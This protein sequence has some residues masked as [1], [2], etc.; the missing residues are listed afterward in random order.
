VQVTAEVTGA[1]TQTT[2]DAGDTLTVT[3]TDTQTFGFVT[4]HGTLS[5][6]QTGQ[7]G[8]DDILT[9]S[10]S[11]TVNADVARFVNTGRNR[12]RDA[13]LAGTT[14]TAFEIGFSPSTDRPIRSDDSVSGPLR[15]AEVVNFDLTT[16]ITIDAGDTLTVAAGEVRPSSRAV[17]S[18]TL[19]VNGELQ[20]LDKPAT[21][22]DADLQ[23]AVETRT[24]G[25]I[26]SATD[27]LI[28]LARLE[29]TL[30]FVNDAQIAISFGPD[31]EPTTTFTR[32]GLEFLSKVLAD[33]PTSFPTSYAYG[34]DDTLPALTDTAL[35]NEVID[36]NFDETVVQDADSDAEWQSIVNL[37]NTDPQTVQNGKL[38]NRQS[39]FLIEGETSFIT[40][41]RGSPAYSDGSATFYGGDF[42]A[43][44][45]EA[46]YD[47]TTDYRIEN[48]EFYVRVERFSSPNTAEDDAITPGV[49]FEVDGTLIEEF[50]RGASF[51]PNVL[52]LRWFKKDRDQPADFELPAG[53]HTISFRITETTGGQ[54]LGEH[55]IDMV[56]I[57]DGDVGHTFDNQVHEDNGYLDAPQPFPPQTVTTTQASTS[58]DSGFDRARLRTTWNDTSGQQ[59]IG[60]SADGS[61]FID[62]SNTQVVTENIGATN[63]A[64]AR[65]GIGNYS[66]NGPRNQSPRLG[67]ESQK[68][69]LMTLAAIGDNLRAEDIG[70]LRL[71]ALIG[72]NDAVGETFAEAG[73]K[74]ADGTLLTR[75]LVP[76]FEKQQGQNVFSSEILSW[77]NEDSA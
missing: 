54:D 64:F 19:T 3:D 60:I 63:E 57:V 28:A 27:E 10:A 41:S 30:P 24:V 23:D 77:Q 69:D 21:S 76:A 20:V 72:G 11:S 16:D 42:A 2:V 22:F 71:Q 32:Q 18:G 14:L 75:S 35:G 36:T 12:L 48:P 39:A 65:F 61:N 17:V 55:V 56:A 50:P 70:A 8:T 53:N 68:V 58:L 67:Y 43:V 45:Q 34:S 40:G 51:G 44:G 5:I 15:T 26:E 33:V 52:S 73:L 74:A 31:A 62:T 49:V 59:F 4:V 37:Q 25:L 1:T 66:P 38:Q 47:F 9:V 46:N 7:A 13:I 6:E 29:Q